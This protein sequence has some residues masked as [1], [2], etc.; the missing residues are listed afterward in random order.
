[1][2]DPSRAIRPLLHLRRLTLLH[3][4]PARLIRKQSLRK[5]FLYPPDVSCRPDFAIGRQEQGRRVVGSYPGL[6]RSCM[7]V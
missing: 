5:H 2:H 7:A 6:N 4:A 1:M 3:K